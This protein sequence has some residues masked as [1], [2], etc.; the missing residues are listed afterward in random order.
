MQAK[1]LW[2]TAKVFLSSKVA[3]GDSRGP[4]AEQRFLWVTEG[5]LGLIKVAMGYSRGSPVGRCPPCLTS[6]E[7]APYRP[8]S[9]QHSSQPL[10]DKDKQR[11]RKP[12]PAG[13][14]PPRKLLRAT[15]GVLKPGKESSGC[16]GREEERTEAGT[17][18]AEWEGS[19]EER[20][21][22]S[23]GYRAGLPWQPVCRTASHNTFPGQSS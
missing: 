11:A 22:G 14:G 18:N 10:T 2:V 6:P 1:L 5:S 23:H 4:S 13:S 17:V 21:R 9:S 7:Q 12:L 8:H 16:K 15:S 3:I 19:A 20:G